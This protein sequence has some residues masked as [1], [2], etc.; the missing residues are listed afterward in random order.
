MTTSK[1]YE[2]RFPK[3]CLQ[4]NNQAK[5][6]HKGGLHIDQFGGA[7]GENNRMHHALHAKPKEIKHNKEDEVKERTLGIDVK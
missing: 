7:R 5:R 1:T 3:Q 6:Q 4:C 2:E